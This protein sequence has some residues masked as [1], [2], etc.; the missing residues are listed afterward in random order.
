MF[1]KCTT[2]DL[3]FDPK[4]VVAVKLIPGSKK[5]RVLLFLTPDAK[6]DKIEV[7]LQY[8]FRTENVRRSQRCLV[9]L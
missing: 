5:P 9:Q 4:Y 1:H 2:A 6:D 3:T 7:F 8:N